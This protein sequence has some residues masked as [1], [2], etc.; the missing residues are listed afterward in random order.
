VRMLSKKIVDRGGA[1]FLH[2]GNDEIDMVNL[3]AAK[4]IRASRRAR[5]CFRRWHVGN[6]YHF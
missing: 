6:S 2:T 1:R 3:P 5:G 4:N